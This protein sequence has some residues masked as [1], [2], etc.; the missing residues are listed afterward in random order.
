MQLD[1]LNQ[2]PLD[3]QHEAGQN[4][5]DTEVQD[6]CGIW[7]T[8][9]PRRRGGRGRSSGHTSRNQEERT[10]KDM[11]IKRLNDN[12]HISNARNSHS[13]RGG[14]GGM[15]GRWNLLPRDQT[16]DH[17]EE[18]PMDP[19]MS[20][21]T[22]PKDLI[23]YNPPPAKSDPSPSTQPTQKMKMKLAVGKQS[24]D[25]IQR[26]PLPSTDIAMDRV[27]REEMSG[28]LNHC[29]LITSVNLAQNPSLPEGDPSGDQDTSMDAH[30]CLVA[31]ISQ[32]LKEKTMEHATDQQD[33]EEESQEGTNN[34]SILDDDMQLAQFQNDMKQE[35]LARRSKVKANSSFKKGRLES[36]SDD[37]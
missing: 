1:G 30:N 29:R 25:V 20:P 2:E 9:G 37:L 11:W 8:V 28:N 31:R 27:V 18:I 22:N 35:A 7:A 4:E 17:L 13:T 16:T 23:I 14:R 3:P 10:N 19:I 24:S 21:N 15:A 5:K 33:M 34:T 12:R 6:V 36:P 32:A 26:I